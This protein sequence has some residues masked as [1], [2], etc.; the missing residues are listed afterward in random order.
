MKEIILAIIFFMNGMALAS[1][2]IKVGSHWGAHIPNQPLGPNDCLADKIDDPLLHP[3]GFRYLIDNTVLSILS[4]FSFGADAVSIN[5]RST[6]D[7]NVVLF[8]DNSLDYRT[9]GSGKISDHT[10][11]EVQALN[12]GWNFTP[13]GGTTYPW[14]R[15]SVIRAGYTWIPTIEEVFNLTTGKSYW[16][17]LRPGSRNELAVIISHL[18]KYPQIVDNSLFYFSPGKTWIKDILKSDL[19]NARIPRLDDGAMNECLKTYEEERSVNFSTLTLE[20]CAL[21]ETSTVRI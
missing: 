6:K 13:D 11:Q 5:P 21:P 1:Q 7:E 16:I 20:G 19:P 18:K 2:R 10:L 9:N 14:R 12:A 8:H 15:V 3:E 17:V 4:A